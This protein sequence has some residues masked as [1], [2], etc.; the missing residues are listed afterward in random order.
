MVTKNL[1]NDPMGHPVLKLC[2]FLDPVVLELHLP[3]LVLAHEVGDDGVEGE[4]EDEHGQTRE[5]RQADLVVQEQDAQHDLEG[6]R[7]V[8]G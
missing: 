4:G 1:G 3:D 7:P 6:G 5:G 8:R 2:T